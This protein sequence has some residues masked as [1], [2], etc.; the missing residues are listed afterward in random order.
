MKNLA[1]VF[2]LLIMLMSFSVVAD[3]SITAKPENLC[4]CDTGVYKLRLKNDATTEKT[5]SIYMTGQKAQWA[6]VAPKS[7]SLKSGEEKP[8][9]VF[10]T[11][12]CFADVGSYTI[13]VNAKSGS[14]SY[15]KDLVVNVKNCHTIE[16]SG[17]KEKTVC[18]GDK[19]TYDI[20]AKN[21]GEFKDTYK[22]K[23]DN[24]K[25]DKSTLTL[26]PGGYDILGLSFDASSVGAKT[27]KTTFE[28]SVI[29]YSKSFQTVIHV[30]ACSDFTADIIEPNMT[31]IG[32]QTAFSVIVKN[33]GKSDD[34]YYIKTDISNHSF[35]LKPGETKKT[36][37]GLTPSGDTDINIEIKSGSGINRTLT[38]HIKTKRCAKFML[39]TAR[40][41][42]VCAGDP[43]KYSIS[44]KNE[45]I[46]KDTYKLTATE[47]SL[48]KAELEVG[49]NEIG[50]T[51]LNIKGLEP[52]KKTITITAESS[53]GVKASQ[54][55]Y[56]D[57]IKCCDVSAITNVEPISVCA[58]SKSSIITE[59]GI[60]N[61]GRS[62]T[63]VIDSPSWVVPDEKQVELKANETKKV[64]LRIKTPSDIGSY[65]PVIKVIS[66]S[67]VDKA[68]LT[69]NVKSCYGMD[70][71]ADKTSSKLCPEE[72]TKYKIKIK[73][74]A[75]IADTFD[76]SLNTTVASL[77]KNKL[78]LDGGETGTI[79]MTVGPINK[80]YTFDLVISSHS[81]PKVKKTLTFDTEFIPT[82]KC[83]CVKLDSVD[84]IPIKQCTNKVVDLN[85]TNCG[86]KQDI[87]ELTVNGSAADW[88]LIEPT[89]LQIEPGS[90]AKSYLA[91]R[92][93]FGTE[94]KDYLLTIT[95]K[96]KK[97]GSDSSNIKIA[98]LE[99][100]STE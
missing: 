83:Y 27:I 42:T 53:T 61:L 68:H 64:L 1:L 4:Q 87:F 74:K 21:T 19:F 84:Y 77:D 39:L 45:G 49:P 67:C 78:N 46:F 94:L 72:S 7:V 91:V 15:K 69:I 76:I 63:Y 90:K 51:E 36:L 3:I 13:T 16:L 60:R 66:G 32:Q 89:S 37:I 2:I 40:N 24:A 31:C 12:E 10:V 58:G 17:I 96:G 80:S 59:L 71:F 11:P 25:A 65:E 57:V 70:A 8:V 35:S 85:L 26:E 54:D 81:D 38:A 33:T 43:V 86:L 92:M 88:A 41:K 62:D 20:K 52:G 98:A 79:T 23:V 50:S 47:G 73:N 30:D 95:A 5:F 22:I 34:V 93:P 55:S 97:G 44:V 14:I 100:N 99:Y 6:S 56:I 28:N 75:N 18:V 48:A 82:A 29:S 9:Y